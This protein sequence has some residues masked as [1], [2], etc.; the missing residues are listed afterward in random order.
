MKGSLRLLLLPVLLFAASASVL[1][2]LAAHY[3]VTYAGGYQTTT[4]TNGYDLTGPYYLLQ[5]GSS[6]GG[7]TWDAPNGTWGD[8]SCEGGIITVFTWTQDYPGDPQLSPG[9]VIILEQSSATASSTG[10][11]AGIA[12]ADDGLGDTPTYSGDGIHMSQATCAGHRYSVKIDPGA[13]F[14]INCSPSSHATIEQGFCRCDVSYS[15]GVTPVLLV[16]GG[17]IPRN[18]DDGFVHI[19]VGQGFSPYL[20][21]GNF[22][23]DSTSYNWTMP[24]MTF[25]DFYVAPD[26]SSGHVVPVDPSQLTSPS[27]HW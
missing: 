7:S 19:L 16:P 22:T 1:P 20:T 18:P 17:A 27:P 13:S 2:A 14:S 24:G 21:A 10:S 11:S 4:R 8:V 12:D 6:W 23:I 26:L 3:V 5:D 25:A 9:S 15:A